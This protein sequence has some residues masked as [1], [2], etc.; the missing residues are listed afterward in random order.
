MTARIASLATT[1]AGL[2][3]QLLKRVEDSQR[4]AVFQQALLMLASTTGGMTEAELMGLIEPGTH[5]K[6][7]RYVE[8]PQ[9]RTVVTSAQAAV[10]ARRVGRG[11]RAHP[12]NAPRCWVRLS[13]ALYLQLTLT[14]QGCNGAHY[15]AER[16]CAADGGGVLC[17]KYRRRLRGGAAERP[18]S[19]ADDVL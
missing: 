5:D 10:L 16:G 13:L 11:V 18:A 2:L 8:P 6:R 12:A 17:S 9:Q 14:W 3:E 1:P 7:E 15:A 4:S 19:H